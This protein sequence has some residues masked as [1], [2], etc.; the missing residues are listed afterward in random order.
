MAF[1]GVIIG[2]KG[3]K[4]DSAE[5]GLYVPFSFGDATPKTI[6]PNEANKLIE[7]VTI[8]ITTPF[9][10]VGATL[11]IGDSGTPM[12]LMEATD[13]EP[14]TPATYQVHPNVSF[15]DTRNLLLTI[16]PGAGATQGAGI[17]SITFQ[18]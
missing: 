14:Q 4:G 5:A 1:A 6:G 18:Q 10:G 13:N 3:D 2:P 15:A 7:R 16:V 8:I 12:G 9:N 11:A 17:V